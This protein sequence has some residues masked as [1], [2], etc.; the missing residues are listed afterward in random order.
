MSSKQQTIK[1]KC[2]I[3]SMIFNTKKEFKDHAR[4]RLYKCD[5]CGKYFHEKQE[6]ENHL[7]EHNP[8]VVTDSDNSDNEQNRHND[9]EGYQVRLPN[10]AMDNWM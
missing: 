3:C 10:E 6:I 1:Y 2:L 9:N 5:I 8:I 4:G 7:T